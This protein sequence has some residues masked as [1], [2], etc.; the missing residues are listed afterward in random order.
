VHDK[1]EF[2][3]RMVK[4]IADM[5][6]DIN[7]LDDYINVLGYVNTIVASLGGNAQPVN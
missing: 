1:E 4:Q 7:K 3:Q 6:N 5:T 2:V